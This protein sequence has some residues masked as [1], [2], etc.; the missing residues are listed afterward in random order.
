M[1]YQ[2]VVYRDV[3]RYSFIDHRLRSPWSPVLQF[4]FLGP[5]CRGLCGSQKYTATPLRLLSSLCIAISRPWSYVK[6]WRMG[7]AIPSS[8]SEKDYNMLVALAGLNSGS[9]MSMSN[10]LVH[11]TRVPTALELAAHLIKSPSQPPG[12]CRS[13][14]SSGRKWMLTM[15][16]I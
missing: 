10:L 6:L 1:S 12:N 7:A 4:F 3:R 16:G 8:L 5:R 11:S 14:T 9:L 2:R 15:S 13:S